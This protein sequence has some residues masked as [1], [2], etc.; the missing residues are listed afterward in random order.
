MS[1]DGRCYFTALAYEI[2][3][4]LWVFIRPAQ[5]AASVKWSIASKL[6]SIADA[7]AICANA[8]HSSQPSS[9]SLANK[10][11]WQIGGVYQQPDI[12]LRLHWVNTSK[13]FEPIYLSSK[14]SQNRSFAYAID[15]AFCQLAD[16]R[17]RNYSKKSAGWACVWQWWHQWHL[18]HFAFHPICA[19]AYAVSALDDG[20]FS[21]AS[22]HCQWMVGANQ[23][24]SAI[25]C[26]NTAV[27]C[28]AMTFISSF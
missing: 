25:L 13:A 11:C 1:S 5:T 7:R 22:C 6:W 2:Y 27:Y 10:V 15:N 26:P 20:I 28:R 21:V 17:G 3:L 14:L 12:A 8:W 9:Q 18:I 4:P 23:I 24:R 16:Y 19:H